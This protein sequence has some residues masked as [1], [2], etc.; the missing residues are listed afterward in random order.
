MTLTV[1]SVGLLFIGASVAV[2]AARTPAEA[3]AGDAGFMMLMVPGVVALF[4]AVSGRITTVQQLR[5]RDVPL[6]MLEAADVVTPHRG[7]RRA[8][9]GRSSGIAYL[10]MAMLGPGLMAAAL[11]NWGDQSRTVSVVTVTFAGSALAGCYLVGPAARFVI[12]PECLCVDTAFHRLRVPRHLLGTFFSNGVDVRLDLADGD[13]LY[14]RVDSPLWDIRGGGYRA[15]R[16][17]QLRTVERIVARLQAVPARPTVGGMVVS[18][19]PGMIS[20]AVVA[21]AAPVVALVTA[22]TVAGR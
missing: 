3:R 10:F 2:Y 17:T 14:F 6:P 18:V 22:L 15:N 13:R 11:V 21:A 20:L 7:A 5:Y 8:S 1:S 12:T 9:V 4:V 16:R 19:R